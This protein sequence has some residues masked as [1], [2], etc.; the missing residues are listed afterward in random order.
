ML[1]ICQNCR[2]LDYRKLCV[3]SITGKISLPNTA[4][5][6]CLSA[7]QRKSPQN[8]FHLAFPHSVNH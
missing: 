7:K 3:P 6:R 1:D 8:C 2:T 4:P 5:Y